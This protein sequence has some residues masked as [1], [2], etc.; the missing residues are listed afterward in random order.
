MCPETIEGT[1]QAALEVPPEAEKYL[2]KKLGKVTLPPLA[3]A[4]KDVDAL[5]VELA[6]KVRA[7]AAVALPVDVVAKVRVAKE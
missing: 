5:P 7:R 6:D 2:G 1:T 3:S 4:A